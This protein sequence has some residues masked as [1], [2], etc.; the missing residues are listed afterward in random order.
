MDKQTTLQG[1]YEWMVSSAQTKTEVNDYKL[2][3]MP[4]LLLLKESS[5]FMCVCVLWY[6]HDELKI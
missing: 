1:K 5:V 6:F 2:R 3:K 4:L